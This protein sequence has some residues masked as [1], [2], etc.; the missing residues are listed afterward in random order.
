M[1]KLILMATA[2]VAVAC[3]DNSVPQ[4]QY[5]ELDLQNPLLAEW[6]TPYQTP[7]FSLIKLEH[8]EPAIDAAIA[9]SRAEI[10]AIVTNPAHT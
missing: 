6:N 5:P 7:P 8:F 1:K 4:A 10:E 3:G 2:F 9:C